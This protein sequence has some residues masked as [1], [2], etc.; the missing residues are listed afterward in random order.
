M[1]NQHQ[2]E[3]VHK[4]PNI[5]VEVVSSWLSVVAGLLVE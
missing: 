2:M 5:E 3:Q 1:S 4:F